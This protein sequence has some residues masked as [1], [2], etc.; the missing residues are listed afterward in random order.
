MVA[1]FLDT[2]RRQSESRTRHTTCSCYYRHLIIQCM[3][4]DIVTVFPCLPSYTCA[5]LKVARTRRT[6]SENCRL[7]SETIT[8]GSSRISEM[9]L[10]MSHY[11]LP[12]REIIYATLTNHQ[13]EHEHEDRKTARTRNK[14]GIRC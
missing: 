2:I 7:D 9:K 14:D 11:V 3:L 10:K 1:I 13:H 6:E 4:R 12:T 5:L 8:V